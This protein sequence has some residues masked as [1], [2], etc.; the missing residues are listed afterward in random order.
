M[1][2]QTTSAATRQL[3]PDTR[4]RGRDAFVREPRVHVLVSQWSHSSLNRERFFDPQGLSMSFALTGRMGHGRM[5]AACAELCSKLCGAVAC[6]AV[7]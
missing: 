6:L 5:V 7:G 2:S 1:A 4:P 3:R